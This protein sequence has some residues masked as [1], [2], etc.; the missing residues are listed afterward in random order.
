MIVAGTDR[1][2]ASQ[3][4]GALAGL[5][6]AR[7]LTEGG[8]ALLAQIAA[9]GLLDELCLTIS[10][11]LAGGQA[12][13]ILAGG[14]PGTWRP[15]CPADAAGPRAGRRRLPVLPVRPARERKD[16]RYPRTQET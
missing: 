5:G 16:L 9:A 13:R 4:V 7:I 11:V 6:H 15:A 14:R 2:S 3:A 10:P 8:P 1:V 12:R